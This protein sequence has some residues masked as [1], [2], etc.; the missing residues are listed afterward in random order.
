[1]NNYGISILI[2]LYNGIEFLHESIGSVID[3]TYNNWEVIIGING[4]DENS[5]IEIKAK[6]IINK[7]NNNNYNI[8]VI[9]YNTKG[10]SQTLNNMVKDAIYDYIALL[11]VDDIWLSTKLEKQI[12]LLKTYDVIGT[13]CK[14]FGN[15]N[16]VPNIPVGDL[17]SH[18]FYSGNPLINSSIIINKQDAF[19]DEK[20][21]LED[22]DMWFKL[23]YMN[24]KF[25]NIPEIL[26]YHRI[27]GNSAFNN[28]NNNYVEILKDKWRKYGK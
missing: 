4:Y 12:L 15:L 22:Y 27:H 7:L 25:Y 16:I 21:G 6:E 18:D 13:Q 10:K 9:Y 5:D 20:T 11:D 3:Q 28:S 17:S 2:P 19:W 24:K 23:Y 26:C 1:M 8:K 14:Y